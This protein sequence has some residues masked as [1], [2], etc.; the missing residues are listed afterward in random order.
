MQ[1]RALHGKMQPMEGNRSADDSGRARRTLGRVRYVDCIAILPSL[2]ILGSVS[3]GLRPQRLALAFVLLLTV[4]AA[5][6][7]WDGFAQPTAPPEGLLAGPMREAALVSDLE[8]VRSVIVPE[9]PTA[10]RAAA[11]TAT[12]EELEEMLV[13]AQDARRSEAGSAAR[14]ASQMSMIDAA[15]PLLPFESLH[16][17]VRAETYRTAAAVLQFHFGDAVR[18]LRVLAVEI[19]AASWSAA[20]AFT[21]FFALVCVLVLGCGGGVLCR[22]SA[23]DLAGYAWTL[24]DAGAFIRPRI[25]S[26]VFAPIFAGVLVGVLLL[27]SLLIGWLASVPLI[28]IVAAMMM[29]VAL[30]CA[31][32][33]AIVV[34]ATLVGAGLL[35]PAVACD[36]CDAVESIQRAGAYILARPLHLAWAVLLSSVALAL[37][38][39]AADIIITWSWGASIASMDASGAVEL[40]RGAGSMRLLEPFQEG[41]AIVVG[42]TDGIAASFIDIWRTVLG[43]ATGAVML[44]VGFACATRA[45]LLLRASADGQ[46]WSDLWMDGEPTEPTP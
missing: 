29:P 2:R 13:D 18:G 31:M 46:E 3:A 32:L 41:P 23:G 38:L 27:P 9:L 37:A 34:V 25:T 39:L 17:A 20:P 6:R 1:D 5:G 11:A 4:V 7:V 19:P 16:E 30:V 44:S 10:M 14:F 43:V 33:A 15:R 42:I 28:N 40:A 8:S 35:A 24:A 21:C 26:L 45:Y 12:L 22:L 36:G